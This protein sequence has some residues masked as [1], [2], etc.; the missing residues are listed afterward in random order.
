MD[1]LYKKKVIITGGAGFIGSHITRRLKREGAEVVLL[2]RHT[3]D[4]WRLKDII[5]EL[6]IIRLDDLFNYNVLENKIDGADCLIHLAFSGVDQNAHD[7][8]SVYFQNIDNTNSLLKLS[9]NKRIKRFIFTGSCFEYPAGSKLDE[10]TVPKAVNIYSA[11]KIS[12]WYLSQAYY[13]M[14]GLNVIGLRPFT[15]YGPS[16]SGYRLIPT[17]ITGAILN[18]EV[19]LTPGYQMRDFIYIDDVVEAYLQTIINEEIIPGE[20]YNICTGKDTSV[21]EVVSEL[22]PLLENKSRVNFEKLPYRDNEFMAL[23]GDYSKLQKSINWNPRVNL[24][25]GLK[26]TVGWFK[27][28]FSKYRQYYY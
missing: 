20:V 9:I 8:G 22:S 19:N 6:H 14:F 28:N 26:L 4:T 27:L 23:S 15:V 13:H 1:K 11:A 7:I 16:E 24:I 17:I 18:R 2:L 3:T 25:D 10:L 12:G 5:D 21:R